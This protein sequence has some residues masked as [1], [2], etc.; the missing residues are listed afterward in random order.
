MGVAELPPL[1]APV[2]RTARRL[3]SDTIRINPDTPPMPVRCIRY[4]RLERGADLRLFH[5]SIGGDPVSAGR[6]GGE[7]GKKGTF[8][9]VDVTAATAFGNGAAAIA[10]VVALLDVLQ[11]SKKLSPQEVDRILSSATALLPSGV[12][13]GQE[14]LKA[15]K[16]IVV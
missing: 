11:S 8:M 15:M 12:T 4:R 7:A 1:M 6:T 5:A 3:Q 14:S 16:S 9:K 10:I 13:V 2:R